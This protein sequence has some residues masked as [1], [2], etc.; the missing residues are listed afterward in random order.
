M[1]SD[2]SPDDGKLYPYREV[3]GEVVKVKYALAPE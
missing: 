1:Y 2:Q 3:V